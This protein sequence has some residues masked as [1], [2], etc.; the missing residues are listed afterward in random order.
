[1]AARLDGETAILGRLSPDPAGGH[2]GIGDR[3]SFL[4]LPYY[5]SLVSPAALL[6]LPRSLGAAWKAVGEADRVWLLGPHPLIV[7]LAWFAR[8][9]G[10][11]LIL[12]VRQDFP[13]YIRS[14]HPENRLLQGTARL[15]ERGFRRRARHAPVVAVGPELAAH[16]VHAERLLEIAV[17]L[18]DGEQ[19]AAGEAAAAARSYDG[20][21]TILSV[22]RLDNEKNPVLL[23]D[24]LARLDSQWRLEVCGEGPLADELERRAAEMGLAERV[25]LAGYV[26]I[27]GGLADRYRNAHVLLHSSLTEGLPQVLIEA[28]AAGLPVV[29]SDVGGIR[30]AVGDRAQLVPSGDAAAAAAA[31]GAVGGDPALRDRLVAAGLEFAREHTIEV[32]SA[33]VARFLE[34][35]VHARLHGSGNA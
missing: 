23:L 22:G 4:P 14:R 28:F 18:V 3:V 13:A 8:L 1:M 25:E 30:A 33:R 10:R 12:G 27:D 21:K 34:A 16:Y 19:I 7:V 31:V 17:S 20:P 32:E 9:R 26:P 11:T 15:L 24:T 5:R 2:Y 35:D 6:A 29:A